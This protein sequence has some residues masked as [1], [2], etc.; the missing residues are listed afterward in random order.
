MIVVEVVYAETDLELSVE[1][2]LPDESRI[3]EAV[4]AALKEPTF[5]DFDKSQFVA[6]SVFGEV[7][8]SN[9]IVFDKDRIEL[10]RPLKRDPREARRERIS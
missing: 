3:A 7:K 5:S 9:Q 1:I 10:L 8:A 2:E 6:T 4:I